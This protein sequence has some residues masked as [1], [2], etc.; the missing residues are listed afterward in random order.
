MNVSTRERATVLAALRLWQRLHEE[1]QAELRNPD[2]PE[3]D[4]AT[5][6]YEFDA[7]DIEEVEDLC[8]RLLH[9]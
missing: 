8:E 7:L 4:I 1:A 3:H 9:D 5:S 2:L 6:L